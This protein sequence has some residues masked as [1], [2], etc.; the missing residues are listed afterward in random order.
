M[1]AN[2]PPFD[3]YELSFCA[4]WEN[5]YQKTFIQREDINPPPETAGGDKLI[6]TMWSLYGHIPNSGVWC[7]GDFIDQHAALNNLSSIL[8]RKLEMEDGATY[9]W[10]PVHVPC[11]RW[12]VAPC[13][14]GDPE[15][16]G[17]VTDLNP[18][19]WR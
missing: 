19:E 3:A 15:M 1:I 6:R 18:K 14:S 9:G 4:E 17:V 10:F 5:E 11:A 7:L 2:N 16:C 13:L 12:C 8:G